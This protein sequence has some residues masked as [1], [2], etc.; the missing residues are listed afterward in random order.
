[1]IRCQKPWTILGPP[2]AIPADLL[3]EDGGPATNQEEV[4]WTGKVSLPHFSG[5]Q[6]VRCLRMGLMINMQEDW[7][8]HGAGA[9]AP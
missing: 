2:V 4:G 7:A 5:Y 1:M 8:V 6:L 3:E 9:R